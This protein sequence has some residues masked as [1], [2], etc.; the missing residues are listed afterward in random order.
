[1]LTGVVCNRGLVRDIDAAGGGY[2]LEPETLE[3][4]AHGSAEHARR[5]H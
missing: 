4:G 2:V 5:A 3:L 1:M